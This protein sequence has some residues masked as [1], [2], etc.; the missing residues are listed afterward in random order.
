[1]RMGMEEKWKCMWPWEGDLWW[2][3]R[4]TRGGP[5]GGAPKRGAHGEARGGVQGGTWG[6]QGGRWEA[7]FGAFGAH[8]STRGGAEGVGRGGMV[9]HVGD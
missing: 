1:M 2:C 6:P 7:R 5:G 9:V 3:K 4:G 8:C